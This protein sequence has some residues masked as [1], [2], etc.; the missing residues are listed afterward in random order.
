M[1]SE[2]LAGLA[3]LLAFFIL[4][5]AWGTG[6]LGDGSRRTVGACWALSAESGDGRRG[7]CGAL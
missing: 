3:R 5:E 2:G 4:V 7:S 6:D 1:T